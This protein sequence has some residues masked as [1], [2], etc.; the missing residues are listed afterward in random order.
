LSEE[1]VRFC[2][3]RAKLAWIALQSTTRV[4][5]HHWFRTKIFYEADPRQHLKVEI[6]QEN[7]GFEVL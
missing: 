2:W 5:A 3:Y 4:H 7:V 1:V 6:Q